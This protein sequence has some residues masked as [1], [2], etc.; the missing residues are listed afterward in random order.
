MYWYK[1][2]TLLIWMFAA[3]N[4]FLIAFIV[5]GKVRQNLYERQEIES[6]I[7]VMSINDITVEDGIASKKSTEVRTASIENL[8]PSGEEMAKIMLG[9]KFEVITDDSGAVKYKS[10][11]MSV[12]VENGN[13]SF[14]DEGAAADKSLSDDKVSKAVELL[15]SYNIDMSSAEGKGVGD[16]IV[17]TYYYDNLPLFEN[18]FYVKMSG[19]KIC[20]AGGKIISFTEKNDSEIE[21]RSTADALVSFLRDERRGSGKVK[22]LS[23]ELGYSVLL[24]DT[25]V[26]FKKTETIPTYKITTDKNNTFYYDARP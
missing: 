17:F 3:I 14:L 22:V 8:I 4:I 10:G 13:L 26:N 19:E 15:K 7:N 24:A 9:E 2:K 16:K 12:S 6:L 1:V 11:T 25:G 21:V 20:E 18:M 5:Q 23:V